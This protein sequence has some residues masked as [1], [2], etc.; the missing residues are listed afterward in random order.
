QQQ[1]AVVLLGLAKL[2]GAE[3]LI[4]ESFDVAALQRRHGRDHKLDARF[5][6]KLFR[7]RGNVGAYRRREDVGLIDDSAGQSRKIERKRG[8]RSERQHQET[9]QARWQQAHHQLPEAPPPPKEPPP[10]SPPPKPPEKPPP[11]PPPPPQPDPQPP[12]KMIGPRR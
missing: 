2:P 3:E 8:Q 1:D 12:G 11:P 4:G 9:G 6:F 7:L 5:F 10:E